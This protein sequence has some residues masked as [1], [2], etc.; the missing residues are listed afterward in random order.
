M[1]QPGKSTHFTEGFLGVCVCVLLK[2]FYSSLLSSQ[3]VKKKSAKQ[4]I[5]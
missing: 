1:Q 5:P 4:T 3:S 2:D